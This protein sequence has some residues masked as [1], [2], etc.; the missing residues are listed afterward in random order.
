[1]IASPAP[2]WDIKR[3]KPPTLALLDPELR[4]LLWRRSGGLD[5]VTGERL[6]GGRFDGHHRKKKSQ[7]RDDSPSNLLVVSRKTHDRLG[8]HEAWAREHGFVVSAYSNPADVAILLHCKRY[9]LLGDD[10]SY[11]DGETGQSA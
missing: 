5:E 4:Q 1:M 8:S 7:G 2:P 9:V 6:I 11:I 3:P 10:F